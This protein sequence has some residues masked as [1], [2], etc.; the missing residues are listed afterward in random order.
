MGNP[1]VG[2]HR[3]SVLP[4]HRELDGEGNTDPAARSPCHVRI[5]TAPASGVFGAAWSYF[6][7]LPGAMQ[8]HLESVGGHAAA[9]SVLAIV[10]TAITRKK[11]STRTT[12]A[13]SEVA[14]PRRRRSRAGRR[15]SR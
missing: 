1:G 3:N 13:S 14:P 4:S 8:Q 2:R 15:R 9:G 6:D 10:C 11:E 12:F 7:G 5:R